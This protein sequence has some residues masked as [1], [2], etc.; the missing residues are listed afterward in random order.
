MPCGKI[1]ISCQADD[2][3]PL[4]E[5]EDFQGKLRK[6]TDSDIRDIKNKI[7]EVGFPYP[8]FVWKSDKNYCLD[9]TE[10][11]LA[12][13]GLEEEGYELPPEFPVVYIYAE[14]EEEA[15][16]K[17][18]QAISAYGV[19]TQNG[20]AELTEGMEIDL[21]ALSFADTYIDFSGEVFSEQGELSPRQNAMKIAVFGRYKIPVSD[22]EIELFNQKLADYE[23]ETGGRAGFIKSNMGYDLSEAPADEPAENAVEKQ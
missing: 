14:T 7:V 20:L 13:K 4:A 17:L 15:K 5:L 11:K 6:Y 19:I 23:R 9:G 2:S 1:K 10:W 12:L 8:F 18:L 16:K 22:K 3:L 21:A